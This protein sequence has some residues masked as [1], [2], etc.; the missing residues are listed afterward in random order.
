MSVLR[1]N[2]TMLVL[3]S[4]L[5]GFSSA[6]ISAA[7]PDQATKDRCAQY[8]QRA[9]QQYQ[10]MTSHPQ[11]KVK[12][13]LRWQDNLDNHYNACL[14]LPEFLR[15]SEEMTRDNHLQACGGL[16]AGPAASPAASG[17]PAMISESE[18]TH[19]A[20]WTFAGG[21]GQGNWDGGGVIADLVVQ[22][23]D[24]TG[25]SILRRDTSR[26][27]SPGLTAVYTGQID[28]NKIVNGVVTWSWTGFPTGTAQGTW[29][30]S[31]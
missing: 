28:G 11:C 6:G 19:S 15:K 1:R 10:L 17:I 20:V 16:T 24:S 7:E 18:N 14:A 2:P 30:A 9:V 21:H 26:S 25:V 22:K 29:N 5:W 12:S 4:L 8:A 27:W 23:W 3:V 13:D 31:W